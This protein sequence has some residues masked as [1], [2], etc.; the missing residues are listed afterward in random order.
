MR[1]KIER[2]SIIC[3]LFLNLESIREI[4][5]RSRLSE[6]TVK[7]IIIKKLGKATYDKTRKN[8]IKLTSKKYGGERYIK[9][10]KLYNKKGL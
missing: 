7:E 5:S 6:T 8:K 4:S 10:R 2:N 9:L 1:E 3:Q